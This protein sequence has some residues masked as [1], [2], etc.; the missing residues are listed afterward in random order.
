MFR[1]CF[2]F[3]SNWFH[4]FTTLPCPLNYERAGKRAGKGRGVGGEGGVKPSS[5]H[6]RCK[7]STSNSILLC[8]VFTLS[9]SECIFFLFL[10][11]R[12]CRELNSSSSLLSCFRPRPCASCNHNQSIKINQK[13]IQLIKGQ[14][15]CSKSTPQL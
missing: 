8:T 1:S 15:K 13:G 9:G 3:D 2:M 12:S 11:T 4:V 5:V 7:Q 10:L 6:T 14:H